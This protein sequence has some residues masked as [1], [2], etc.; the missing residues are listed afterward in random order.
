[1]MASRALVAV[2]FVSDVL[3][4]LWPVCAVI[5]AEVSEVSWKDTCSSTLGSVS[6]SL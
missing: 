5:V 2:Y 6:Y 1:M 4:D 3:D